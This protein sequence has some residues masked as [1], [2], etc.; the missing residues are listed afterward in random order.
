MEKVAAV[1][2]HDVIVGLLKGKIF[3]INI[4]PFSYKTFVKNV[5]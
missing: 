3:F 5:R 2:V 1:Q 4:T